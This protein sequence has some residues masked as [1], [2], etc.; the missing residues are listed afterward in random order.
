MEAIL[1]TRNIIANFIR[2]LALVLTDVF[3]K[4]TANLLNRLSDSAWK[5]TRWFITC[6]IPILGMFWFFS[7]PP[8]TI[9]I[10]VLVVVLLN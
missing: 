2:V 5:V 3:F 1:K 7:L 4:K 8:N 6:A 10:V 9:L